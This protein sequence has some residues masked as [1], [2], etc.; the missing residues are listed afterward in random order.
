V[1][2]N[3]Y[4]PNGLGGGLSVAWDTVWAPSNGATIAGKVGIGTPNTMDAKA[5]WYSTPVS[6]NAAVGAYV[7][8]SNPLD[9]LTSYIPG[10]DSASPDANNLKV[11]KVSYAFPLWTLDDGVVDP[12]GDMSVNIQSALKPGQQ[13]DITPGVEWDGQLA[14]VWTPFKGS[15]PD[16]NTQTIGADLTTQTGQQGDSPWSVSIAAKSGSASGIGLYGKAG[17]T[18]LDGMTSLNAVAQAHFVE[19]GGDWDTANQLFPLDKQGVLD[20][21]FPQTG[22]VSVSGPI[23][24]VDPVPY[25]NVDFSNGGVPANAG[26][27]AFG[28]VSPDQWYTL[29]GQPNSASPSPYSMLN[30]L[31]AG[32]TP[33]APAPAPSPDFWGKVNTW[34]GSWFS[35]MPA[36]DPMGTPIPGGAS[37]DQTGTDK[38]ASAQQ[39]SS[40]TYSDAFSAA[41]YVTNAALPGSA[42]Q[43]ATASWPTDA[44]PK[45][46]S[47]PTNGDA[48]T[49]YPYVTNATQP[50]GTQQ[51]SNTNWPTDGNGSGSPAASG[52][53]AGQDNNADAPTTDVVMTDTDNTM[54]T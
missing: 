3:Y 38:A 20:M 24:G 21:W 13:F 11:S 26:L 44:V 30:S 53:S 10:Y 32:W 45:Q 52:S 29:P 18:Y 17:A 15:F 16:T 4:G 8:I 6:L 48:F 49:A 54:P 41:P 33:T 42:P 25:L 23:P 31:P 35:G 50:S 47:A 51:A 14:F 9:G 7:D 39:D 19:M 36:T 40:A 37:L 46:A 43:A 5:T 28:N 27:G 22:V 12:V 1:S 34:F 2:G